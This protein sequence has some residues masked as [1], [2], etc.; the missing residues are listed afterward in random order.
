MLETSA[1]PCV[2]SDGLKLALVR[3][4]ASASKPGPPVLLQ[5][6]LGA[7]ALTFDFPGRSLARALAAQG[8]DCYVSE[9][10]G[11]GGSD[12]PKTSYGLDEFLE[13]DI[14]AILSSVQRA[15]GQDR[16]HWVGHSLGGILGMFYAM[17]HADGPIERLITI[18]SALDYSQGPNAFSEMRSARRLAGDWL[19]MIPLGALSRLNGLVAGYGPLLP[20]EKTNFWRSNIEPRVSRHFLS[21]GFTQVPLRLLDDLATTFSPQGFSRAQGSIAYLPRAADLRIPT[22]LIAGS[23]DSQCTAHAIDATARLLSGTELH[24]ARFGK[25]YGQHDEYGHMDLMVGRHAEHEVWPTIAHWL[26]IDRAPRV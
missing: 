15:S 4:R 6:G 26:G 14:P 17:E 1:I 13:R 21:R 7:N 20:A 2:A 16:V 23:A 24:I 19:R 10:R 18:G 9:L 25:P 3:T 5:H 22:C 12:R 11:A 8:F